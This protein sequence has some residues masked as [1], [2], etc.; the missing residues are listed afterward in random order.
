MLNPTH[1]QVPSHE[2]KRIKS[3]QK[4]GMGEP[5]ANVCIVFICGL[6]VACVYLHIC[7]SFPSMQLSAFYRA[8]EMSLN[9]QIE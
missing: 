8:E 5:H 9:E 2:E 6:S 3:G 4:R 1:V 7:H